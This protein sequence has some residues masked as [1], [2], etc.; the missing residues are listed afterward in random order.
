M[1]RDQRRSCRNARF[2]LLQETWIE[3]LAFGPTP[4]QDR[5]IQLWL[6]IFPVNWRQTG[7]PEHLV[8]QIETIRRHLNGSYADL[9]SAMVV[10]RAVLHSLNGFRNRRGNPNENLGRELLELFSLGEGHYDEADVIAAARALT[11]YRVTKGGK[12]RLV[13]RF[14][15]DG[16]KTILG[17]TERFDA[18]GLVAWLCEQPA[19]PRHITARLWLQL[20]GPLPSQAR[21]ASIAGAWQQQNLAIPWLV[22]TLLQ[23]DEA[24]AS[25]RQGAMVRDPIDL[26]IA[27]LALLGSRHPD[28][29]AAARIHLGRMGQAAFEPPSVKGWPVNQEWLNLRW[30]EARR[31]GLL[32]LLADEEVW[33]SRA[34]PAQLGTGLTPIAPVALALPASAGRDSLA[35]LFIDPVW[36]LK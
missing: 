19:T 36:Q 34:L 2:N 33:L 27:S 1:D 26:V 18:P 31:R 10:D 28:A 23:S 6:G 15:D 13:P 30:L 11:G 29:L 12:V 20:V 35:Q 22:L 17:R 4:L 14:H 24:S 8:S 32:A 16:A 3:R 9:L 25:I 7:Q 21:L 5:L